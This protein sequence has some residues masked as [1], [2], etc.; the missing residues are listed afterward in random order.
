LSISLMCDDQPHR[1]GA[2]LLADGA[3][4]G[5]HGTVA[6]ELVAVLGLV[7]R[8]ALH[9]LGPG[10]QDVELAVLTVLAPLDVHRAAV[11]LLD[12]QRVLG[13]LGHVGIVQRIAVAQFRR[14]VHGAHQ[15]AGGQALVRGREF[16]ADQLG[17][18]VAADDG[19]L[20]GLQARLVHIELIGIDGAL[21]HRLAQAVAGGDEDHVFEAALGVDGEHHAG[22]TDI[23]AHH[24]LHAGRQRH[25]GMGKA[26]VHPVADGAVVVE[27]GED[28]LH[29][30]QHVVDAVHVQEGFLLAGE[31]RIGQV[32]GRGRRAH[33]KAGAGVA[34]GQFGERGTH[35][36]FEI[37]RERCVDH[38]LAD[39]RACGGQGVDVVGVQRVEAGVDLL[40]QAAMGQEL[41]EGMRRGGKAAGHAHAGGGELADH[42]AEAGVLA[43]NHLDVM[44]SQVFKRDDQGGRQMGGRHGKAPG[45]WEKRATGGPQPAHTP[46]P[47]AAWRWLWRAGQAGHMAWGVRV[48]RVLG[49]PGRGCGMALARCKPF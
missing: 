14:V 24:A 6:L 30:V 16:H 25:V 32:F 48:R 26:L 13:Q 12:D 33:R 40:G 37:G 19:L 41:A 7:G 10:L 29:L 21:H 49:G 43:A 5:Q 38:P 35:R 11:V 23:A 15:L 20:A 3:A 45:W 44:H 9:R 34:G 36:G 39:L 2:D 42:L 46:A 17:S 18:Q 31:R 47:A 27:A 4:F 8:L 22:R 1:A 28:L